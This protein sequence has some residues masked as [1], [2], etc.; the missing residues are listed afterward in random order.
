MEALEKI[1]LTDRE[2]TVLKLMI[3]GCSNI[4]ISKSANISIH[5]AKAH[6]SSILKKYNAKTRT[7]AC[8]KAIL[9]NNI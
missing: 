8:V 4:E 3:K 7:A 6:V 5:T 9:N 1:Y 2:K